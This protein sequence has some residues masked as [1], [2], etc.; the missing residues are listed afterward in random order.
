M[1]LYDIPATV[2][3]PIDPDVIAAVADRPSVHGL[4]D[5]SGDLTAVDAA[6]RRTPDSFTVFQG[7]DAQLY[8]SMDLGVTGG[9]NALSQAIPEV[10]LALGDAIRAGDD[11]R[12]L[13]LHRGGIAPLFETCATHGFAPV[14]KAAAEERGYVPNA[15]VRPPLTQPDEAARESIA[16]AVDAALDVV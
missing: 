15:A 14:A 5:S 16:T 12:A 8:P 2:G 10:F 1:Y 9:I 4:K 3:E 13:E 11:A 6:L 7:V